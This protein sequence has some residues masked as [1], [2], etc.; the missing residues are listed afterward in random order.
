MRTLC[1]LI[2]LV[3]AALP[4]GVG[5]AR[6]Q[7]NDA[8]VS[9]RIV[10]AQTGAPIAGAT[11]VVANGTLTNQPIYTNAPPP[12]TAPM[13]T[14]AP[15][16]SF[17][18]N[19]LQQPLFQTWSWGYTGLAYPAEYNVEWIQV[20]PKPGDPH[21]VYNGL[22]A[23]AAT[24]AWPPS[25][26]VNVGIIELDVP[27]PAER[28]WVAQVNYDRSYIGFPRV[29]QPVALEEI[30]LL[31][32]RYRAALHTMDHQCSA[33][34]FECLTAWQYMIAHHGMPVAENLAYEPSWRAA[35]RAWISEIARCTN[36][37]NRCAYTEETGHCINIMGG[38]NWIGVAASGLYSVES[39]D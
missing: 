36:G 21:V 30:H 37:W 32:A 13:T 39:L 1:T 31:A 23:L 27:T 5:V 3:A 25:G 11:V 26:N 7:T 34:N 10:D 38:L 18:V 33:R 14:T 9:G 8:T 6:A 20:F 16:G 35:E 4:C 29:Q 22:W 17:A 24:A 28:A 2:L 15:D 12:G 19:N